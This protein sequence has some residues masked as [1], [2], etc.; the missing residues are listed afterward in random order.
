MDGRTDGRAD[1]RTDGR[2]DWWNDRYD[3]E[4]INNLLIYS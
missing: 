4:C 2:A 3:Q 1:G